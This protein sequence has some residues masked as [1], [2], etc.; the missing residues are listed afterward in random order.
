MN[1]GRD[2]PSGGGQNG[3]KDDSY[4]AEVFMSTARLLFDNFP[5]A[6]FHQIWTEHVNMS[7]RL[8][9][10]PGSFRGSGQLL[11]STWATVSELLWGLKFA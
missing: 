10:V 4:G 9:E 3:G 7:E 5:T 1:S 6:D 8:F 2:R 11:C